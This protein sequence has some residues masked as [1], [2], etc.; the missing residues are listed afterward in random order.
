MRRTSHVIFC[1]MTMMIKFI[2]DDELLD[3]QNEI[4]QDE[5]L[6]DLIVDNLFLSQVH[7]SLFD[8]VQ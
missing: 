4:L 7:G 2:F 3:E 8:E 1:Q 5:D 6:F